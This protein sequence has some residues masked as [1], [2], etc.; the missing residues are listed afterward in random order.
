MSVLVKPN[1]LSPEVSVAV[2]AK[3]VLVN[4]ILA[5]AFAA[6]GLKYVIVGYVLLT[7]LNG[8]FALRNFDPILRRL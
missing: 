6:K 3:S 7:T 1:Q 8:I 4:G 5:L 2:L